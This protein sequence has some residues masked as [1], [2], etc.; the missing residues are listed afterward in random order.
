MICMKRILAEISK[1]LEGQARI[2]QASER[3]DRTVA[4]MG[5]MHRIDE[6]QGAKEE[7]VLNQAPQSS[8]R[9]LSLYPLTPSDNV[10]LIEIMIT[11]PGRSPLLLMRQEGPKHEM[12]KVQSGVRE[13][14]ELS[15]Q[16]CIR[17]CTQI[18]S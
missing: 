15:T 16:A 9:Q 6:P 1:T 11:C 5:D 10:K 17:H 8:K 4:E 12:T 18:G 2:A 7:M 14:K 3:S 13:S